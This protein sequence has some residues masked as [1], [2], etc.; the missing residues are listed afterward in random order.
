MFVCLCVGVFVCSC[1]C[2]FVCLCAPV[3][4]CWCFGESAYV[5]VLV[6]HVCT[7]ANAHT[8]PCTPHEL[9]T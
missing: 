1:I 7:F 9:V 4:V 6:F 3:F 2:V 8:V 5:Y